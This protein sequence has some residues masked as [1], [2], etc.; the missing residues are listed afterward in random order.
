MGNQPQQPWSTMTTSQKMVM[1]GEF[2]QEAGSAVI[3]LAVVLIVSVPIGLLLFGPTGFL[4]ILGVLIVVPLAVVMIPVQS[5]AAKQRSRE[6]KKRTAKL[7]EAR[8]RSQS[9]G[10]CGVEPEARI[11]GYVRCP[12]CGELF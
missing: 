5:R 8:T 3:W 6:A 10:R 2:L 11:G 7:S 12:N 1:V 9:C 4:V